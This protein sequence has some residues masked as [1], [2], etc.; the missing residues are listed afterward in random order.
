MSRHN[1]RLKKAIKMN[2]VFV[3]S[4]FVSKTVIVDLIRDDSLSKED[5]SKLVVLYPAFIADNHAYRLGDIFRHNDELYEVIQAHT[6]LPSWNPEEL[7]AIYKS[8]TAQGIVADFKQPTGSHDVYPKGSRVIFEGEV[9]ESLVD[10][11]GFSPSAHKE[12]WEKITK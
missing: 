7:P 5:M 8:K 3:A 4:E 9:W 11:N 1:R 10:G 2:K 12:S 6:S